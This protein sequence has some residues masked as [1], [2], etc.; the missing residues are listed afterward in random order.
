[1]Q[2]GWWIQLPALFLTSKC[3]DLIEPLLVVPCKRGQRIASRL[4]QATYRAQYN[5]ATAGATTFT[6]DKVM[7]TVDGENQEAFLRQLG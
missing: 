1:M 3:I 4:Q 2:I 7:K 6:T 5:C